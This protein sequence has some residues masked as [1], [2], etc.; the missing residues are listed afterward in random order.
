MLKKLLILLF[1][2]AASALH[3]ANYLTFTAEEDSSSFGI[4]SEWGNNPDMQYSLDDG[5]TWTK[6]T[7]DTLIPLPNKKKALL[8]GYNPQGISR[9]FDEVTRFVMTGRIAASGSVMSLIDNVGESVVIPNSLCFQSLF[10]GCASLTQAPELPAIHLTDRC[11]ARMFLGCTNLKEAPQLPAMQLTGGCYRGMFSECTSLTEA[12]KLPATHL[13]NCCYDWMFSGCTSLTKAPIL[14]ATQ[15]QYSCYAYMFS[16]CTSLTHAPQLPATQ[17]A[18]SCYSGMFEGCTSL[19]HAPQLPATQLAMSCYRGMFSGCSSLTAAPELP[20]IQL[21][22][23]CYH[24]MFNKCTNLT[25]APQLPATSLADGCYDGMFMGCTSLTQ[26]PELPATTLT[27]W[28]YREMF[29]DCTGLTEASQIPE[30][31]GHYYTYDDMYKGC[32]N[33]PPTFQLIR[34]TPA[35]KQ[36]STINTAEL[37]PVIKG[38]SPNK[39]LTFTAE[40]DNVQISIENKGQGKIY[41]NVQY[42]TNGGKKWKVLRIGEQIKLPHK[43]DKALLRGYNAQGFSFAL[44][45]YIRFVMTGRV[46]ASGS[47]MSLIDGIGKCQKIP[48]AYCFA[49]LFDSCASL[50]QAPELPATSLTGWCYYKMFSGCTSLT[51]AP[52]LPATQLDE[53]CY[54]FMFFGCVNLRQ[55]PELPATQTLKGCYN[56]MF[57]GCTSLTKAPQLP[58]TQ[59]TRGCYL[60]MFDSCT[61]LTK[62]PELPATI[63]ADECYAGMFNGCANLKEA[64][65]LPAKR[66]S[67]QCYL[68]MFAGCTQLVRA[69]E[70]PADVSF[71]ACYAEMFAGCTNLKE[72]PQLPAPF[73]TK[74]C[75]R[76]MFR[77]CTSLTQ[78]PALN[79]TK[80]VDGCYTEMFEGCTSLKEIPQLPEISLDYRKFNQSKKDYKTEKHIVSLGNDTIRLHILSS[81]WWLKRHLAG[82][83]FK[84]EDNGVLRIPDLKGKDRFMK[85]E[86][87]N[88]TNFSV[89]PL[90]D[91]RFNLES[92]DIATLPTDKEVKLTT[93][94]PEGELLAE[95]TILISRPTFYL[96]INDQLVKIDSASVMPS[97]TEEDNVSF[98]VFDENGKEMEVTHHDIRKVGVP[99][100]GGVLI[101]PGGELSTNEKHYLLKFSHFPL[102]IYIMYKN[103]EGKS[104]KKG[105]PF[106]RGE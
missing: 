47:V 31:H 86:G 1:L 48:N 19:T 58:A 56:N 76:G 71:E 16:K 11:Y 3:A 8:R 17:L 66:L 53:W 40:S 12:P 101:P 91:N 106:F 96:K 81:D 28:C 50:T 29:M 68:R 97:F 36:E 6:L 42:S 57:R 77:G 74:D 21:Q 20:A 55:A 27:N 102:E 64:P 100:M 54:C 59:L 78:A 84:L 103:E 89:S 43:G 70:L 104:W 98:A 9:D 41:P 75:Y 65:K 22:A 46:A 2:C 35:P 63:M 85:C 4:L 44:D 32:T 60:F 79:A 90:G 95:V 18:Q 15:L 33:L 13:E 38:F 39:C 72:A 87:H 73:M 51:E 34:K 61:S 69:P 82:T 24:N 93:T 67:W 62:A 10:A 25:K 37:F 80:L 7:N 52:Q 49:C 88:I 105:I 94:S 83:N 45:S 5:K 92:I 14:P 99:S 30:D 23:D 26:T